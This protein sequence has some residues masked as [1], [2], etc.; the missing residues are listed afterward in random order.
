MT[1]DNPRRTVGAGPITVSRWWEAGLD[2]V[3]VL[4]VIVVVW[5]QP[6]VLTSPAALAV[7]IGVSV[8]VAARRR[9]ALTAA[10]VAAAV[11]AAGALV[12]SDVIL[13][14]WV[15]AQVC[16]FSVPLRR[17][18]AATLGAAVALAAVLFTDAVVR[19][20][21]APLDP[22]SLALVGWTT[23]IAG[24]GLTL[25]AQRDHMEAVRRQADAAIAARNSEIRRRV[26][27]ERLRIARDLH[28]AVAHNIAVISLHAGAAEQALA[29]RPA[30][31]R[32]ALREVRGAS[33]TVLGEMQ[34]ILRVL[35]SDADNDDA[36]PIISAATVP[37]LI[38]HFRALGVEV[39]SDGLD[40][41]G[42]EPAADVAA[43]RLL[44]EALTNAH[45]HGTG[46]IQVAATRANGE[47]RLE[48][49][50]RVQLRRSGGT[51]GFGLI[52]MRERVNS[53]GGRLDTKHEEDR[54]V[55][56]AHLPVTHERER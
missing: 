23:A 30:D 25:R 49:S 20:R 51:A 6:G 45:R 19:T 42:L 28:D 41:S 27:D 46:A 24:A 32:E 48:V 35:R 38:A 43:Y 53:A 16:L 9:F 52:G 40:L 11:S 4:S 44:Q 2:A 26:S 21:V 1:V 54:F 3:A 15:L 31:A 50:N 29:G 33:R 7:L 8:A 14:V 39:V 10:A 5:R 36:E 47:L 22:V 34:S 12:T 18:R 37:G 17:S 55:L 13:A 56:T